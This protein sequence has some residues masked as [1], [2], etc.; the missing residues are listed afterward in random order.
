MSSPASS[1]HRARHLDDSS[2][3][4]VLGA[5]EEVRWQ[6]DHLT[7]PVHH[8]HLQLRAGWRGRL[9]G[10]NAFNRFWLGPTD[11]AGVRARTL[12]LVFLAQG[13]EITLQYVVMTPGK[14]KRSSGLSPASS[15]TSK[16][17][18]TVHELT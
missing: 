1:T 9:P 16:T 3:V 4:A 15:S 10:G 17:L 12:Q 14:L 5:V 2:A 8:Y 18:K 11:A 13:S 7:Q 6:A